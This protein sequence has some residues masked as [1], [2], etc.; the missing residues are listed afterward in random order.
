MEKGKRINLNPLAYNLSFLK[1]DNFKFYI[2]V[3]LTDYLYFH[4]LIDIFDK[5]LLH[6]V[7]TILKMN[8]HWK[9]KSQFYCT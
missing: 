9:C 5:Y 4:Y 2:S 6:I 8:F 3:L 1:Y 7:F